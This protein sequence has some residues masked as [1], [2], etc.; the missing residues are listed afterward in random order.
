MFCWDVMMN[1]VEIL[2]WC[3][4]L[5]RMLVCCREWYV[6]QEVPVISMMDRPYSIEEFL[7]SY[8]TR[9]WN[10]LMLSYGQ[11]RC[12]SKY[13]VSLINN[14]RLWIF[15]CWMNIFIKMFILFTTR[16]GIVSTITDGTFFVIRPP[17]SSFATWSTNTH[18]L[19]I[20]PADDFYIKTAAKTLNR[21]RQ[22]FGSTLWNCVNIVNCDS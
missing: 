22:Y 10:I 17:S 6:C 1:C 16:D 14:L 3:V 19:F 12:V 9:W 21:D 2:K 7:L 11:R 18:H 8:G 4:S 5:R 20:H 13:N 15:C